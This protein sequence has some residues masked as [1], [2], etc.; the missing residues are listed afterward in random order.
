MG[1]SLIIIIPPSFHREQVLITTGEYP[2]LQQPVRFDR[3]GDAQRDIFLAR[4]ENG[5]Y[6]V[7]R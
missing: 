7:V 6:V 5:R 1:V 2:G 4:I 3:F